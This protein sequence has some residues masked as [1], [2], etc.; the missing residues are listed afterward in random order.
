MAASAAINARTV[1]AAYLYSVMVMAGSCRWIPRSFPIRATRYSP[2]QVKRKPRLALSRKVD[3]AK[4][5]LIPRYLTRHACQR[6]ERAGIDIVFSRSSVRRQRTT[7]GAGRSASALMHKSRTMVQTGRRIMKALIAALALVTLIASPTFARPAARASPQSEFVFPT[8][9]QFC[10]S[11][12]TDFCH[13]RGYH[14]LPGESGAHNHAIDWGPGRPTTAFK[15][16]PPFL[17]GKGQGR[18]EPPPFR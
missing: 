1:V 9:Q 3:W 14:L 18:I 8:D 6:I 15:S 7:A 12:R 17:S 5:V 16:G 4:G 13:W 10:Q 2:V 11:G